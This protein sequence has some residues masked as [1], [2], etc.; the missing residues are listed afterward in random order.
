VIH[1]PLILAAVDVL[2]VVN[3]DNSLILL[4]STATGIALSAVIY[5]RDS[6]AKPVKLPSQA[7]QDLFAYD[8]YT[9]QLYRNTIIGFVA[10]SS[11]LLNGFDRIGI[12]GVGN[13]FG[14][15]TLFSGQSL[16]YST[17]GQSQFYMLTILLGLTGIGLWLCYPLLNAGL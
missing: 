2:P 11:R 13:F 12:D 14:I 1:L 17:S 7:L 15:A 5:L 4:W 8:F 16:K 9:P 3:G 10:V 6:I